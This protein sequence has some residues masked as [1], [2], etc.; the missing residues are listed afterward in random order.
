MDK[1]NN[2]KKQSSFL[3]GWKT[4]GSVSAQVSIKT[5]TGGLPHPMRPVYD[6]F[7]GSA[8]F[9]ISAA[10]VETPIYDP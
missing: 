5:V 3:V 9:H 4:T 10:A 7:W 6:S 2:G 1:T 8:A